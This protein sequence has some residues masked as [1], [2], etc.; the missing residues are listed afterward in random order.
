MSHPILKKDRY[1]RRR[2]LK[3][4]II[5]PSFKR[6]L[7]QGSWLRGGMPQWLAIYQHVALQILE[8]NWM[9]PGF[10]SGFWN[11]GKK[12][13]TIQMPSKP[14]WSFS[15]IG[16]KMKKSATLKLLAFCDFTAYHQIFKVQYF[17]QWQYSQSV[18][19]RASKFR[20][21]SRKIDPQVGNEPSL[22]GLQMGHWPKLVVWQKSD[23]FGKNWDFGPKKKRSLLRI[24]H[25]LATTGKSCSKKK[26]ARP[27]WILVT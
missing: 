8:Y 16:K 10:V 7:L 2:A 9:L 25:V 26:V 24:H 18:C 4:I 1:S 14:K 23:F 3:A 20:T 15:F 12:G 17:R 21:E 5:L 13:G 22:R 19:Q 11:K 27:K 6:M